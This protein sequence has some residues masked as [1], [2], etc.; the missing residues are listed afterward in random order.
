MVPS[1]RDLPIRLGELG[2]VHR[3]EASGCL[4][5]LLRLRQF[6]QDDGHVFC[7]DDQVEA[8]LARVLRSMLELYRA[9]G[10]AEPRVA[11]SS[12]PP[13]R[14]GSDSIWDRAERVLESAARAAGISPE[15]QAGQG[16]FYG[17]KLEVLLEDH[18]G[19]AWQA[20]TVQL[21]YLLPE[22]FGLEY[23]DAAG[24]RQRPVM[25]HRALLGSLERFLGLL[26]ERHGA[27]VPEWLA[28]EQVVVVPVA[29]AHGPFA[30][31]AVAELAL[32]GVRSALDERPERLSRRVR[33]AHARGVPLVAVVG[34]REVAQA[35]LALRERDGS[36][37]V[38][39]LAAALGELE[40]RFRPAA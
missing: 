39:P 11:F 24:A 9:F 28:P 21:D 17:P 12:R 15:L 20:G 30:A 8:E 5:G 34:E 40:K 25:I 37:R 32:R 33:D 4:S 10:I 36:C 1:H 26:L 3:A 18:R 2:L 23:V 22:R 16:A 19:H 35:A 29:A 31:L 14:A 13:V 7:R 6:C 38:A 27:R